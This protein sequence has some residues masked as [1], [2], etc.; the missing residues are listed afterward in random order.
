MHDGKGIAHAAEVSGLDARL[1]LVELP[2]E[3][4]IA[5]LGPRAGMDLAAMPRE[6]TDIVTGFRPDHDAF[7][8]ENWHT[9][10]ERGPQPYAAAIV[11]LPRARAAGEALVAEA[12]RATRGP[13]LVDGQK[14]DGIEAMLR[15]LRDRGVALDVISK[16]HGK[17]GRFTAAD[18]DLSAWSHAPVTLPEGFSTAPGAFSSDGIDPGSALLAGALPTSLRGR[19]ADLGAG[20]GFL[21]HAV[22]SRADVIEV[23][24]IEADRAALA[25][26]RRNITDPRARFHWADALAFAPEERFDAVVMNPPF[27]LRRAADPGLGLAFIAA[28]ARMLGPSGALYLVAN[29]HLPYDRALAGAFREVTE[30]GATRSF[31]AIRAAHPAAPP[32]TAARTRLRSRAGVRTE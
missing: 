31:R 17:L 5:V 6:R 7:I 18:V 26:A 1:A 21:A 16:A 27:H 4:R 14:T 30:I 23:H 8:A 22:L 32:R 25:A 11:V 15:A 2:A 9:S 12:V 13:V 28:A 10:F 3:G 24:L 19:V 20:W 29:R